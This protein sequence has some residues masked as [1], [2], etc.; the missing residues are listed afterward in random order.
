MQR[1]GLG[2]RQYRRDA[3]RGHEA[4]VQV[5]RHQAQDGQDVVQGVRGR[6]CSRDAGRWAARPD[7]WRTAS[8]AGAATATSDPDCRYAAADLIIKYD[9][10]L[11]TV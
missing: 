4:R 11:D 2:Q 7:S 6:Q 3:G 1:R 8:A 5:G 10:L 9:M